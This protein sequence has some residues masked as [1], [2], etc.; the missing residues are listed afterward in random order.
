[1]SSFQARNYVVGFVARKTGLSPKKNPPADSWINLKGK[2]K[3][4]APD[5][6]VMQ[7]CEICDSM[8]NDFNGSGIRL[9]KRPMESLVKLVIDQHPSFPVKVVKLYVKVNFHARLR[10]L[11]NNIKIQSLSNK[12]SIRAYKQTAQFVN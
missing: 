8:F 2:G 1:M 12:K 7:I 5:D 4:F 6:N 11:N 3:L 9:C 10:Q